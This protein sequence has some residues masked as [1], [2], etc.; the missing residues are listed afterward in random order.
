[1]GYLPQA[2]RGLLGRAPAGA[3]EGAGSLA[4]TDA[5]HTRAGGGQRI[6]RRAD[7]DALATRLRQMMTLG[8]L[9]LAID[10]AAK[11]MMML[12]WT[13]QTTPHYTHPNPFA[14][15]LV[16]AIAPVVLRYTRHRWMVIALG[17]CIGGCAGNLFQF[18]AGFPVTDFVP[19][20]H[21]LIDPS[22][23]R[24][25]TCTYMCNLADIALWASVPLLAF[26]FVAHVWTTG[27]PRG[28]QAAA[29]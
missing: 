20:P 16:L 19:V 22:C 5:A 2:V 17:V 10:W 23:A 13:R 11:A 29:A 6:Q 28:P 26:A 25:Y 18:M 27:R 9:V 4:T 14:L 7:A 15:L 12:F 3:V 8:L 24:G 21:L 1:M